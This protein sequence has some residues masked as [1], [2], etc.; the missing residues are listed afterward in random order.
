MFLGNRSAS[1]FGDGP[2][3]LFR[4]LKIPKTS[5]DLLSLPSPSTIS[6]ELSTSACAW[7]VRRYRDR[8]TRRVPRCRRLRVL[9]PGLRDAIQSVLCGSVGIVGQSDISERDDAPEPV[10]AIDHRQAT[11]FV[12]CHDSGHLIEFLVLEAVADIGGH[13]VTH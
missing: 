4:A 7:P 8:L 3:N 10:L 2:R 9:S 12:T 6:D 13:H 11:H 5:T 1:A